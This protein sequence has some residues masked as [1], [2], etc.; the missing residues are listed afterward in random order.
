M[1]DE[2]TIPNFA[3]QSKRNRTLEEDTKQKIDELK[4][5]K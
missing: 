1:D 2:D 4:L 5:Q 3:V